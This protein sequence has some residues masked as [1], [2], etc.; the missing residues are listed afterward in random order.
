[1]GVNEFVFI[2]GGWWW[3][4]TGWGLWINY[5]FLLGKVQKIIA[6]LSIVWHQWFFQLSVNK[7]VI[8]GGS[9]W[10]HKTGWSL[11]VNFVFLLA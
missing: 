8:I 5:R 3:H 4:K 11:W 9:W 2:G 6:I 1:L 10:W 7:F